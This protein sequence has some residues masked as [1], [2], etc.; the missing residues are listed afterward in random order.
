M[1]FTMGWPIGLNAMRNAIYIYIYVYMYVSL[2]IFQHALLNLKPPL[3]KQGSNAE[4]CRFCLEIKK[5]GNRWSKINNINKQIKTTMQP[6]C[7]W[8]SPASCALTDPLDQSLRVFVG[9][10]WILDQC[11]RIQLI[12]PRLRDPIRFCH[13]CL[14]CVVY[15]LEANISND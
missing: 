15:V 3:M 4:R 1:R 2:L 5:N 14:V 9:G 11:S 13:V 12:H 6:E 10:S 7:I 8:A